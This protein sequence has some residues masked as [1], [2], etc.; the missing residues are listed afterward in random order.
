MA[1]GTRLLKVRELRQT[2]FRLE[3]SDLLLLETIK[4]RYNLRNRTVAL[5]FVLRYWAQKVLERR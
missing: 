4:Q 1:A 3:D 2:A 5:R